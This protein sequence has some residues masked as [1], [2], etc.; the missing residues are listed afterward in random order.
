MEVR[1]AMTAQ[2]S[3]S[4][5]GPGSHSNWMRVFPRIELR[6]TAAR[7]RCILL[8]QEVGELGTTVKRSDII[9]EGLG[10]T[11]IF[12]SY[13]VRHRTDPRATLVQLVFILRVSVKKM[14]CWSCNIF[15]QW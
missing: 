14:N 11:V 8:L 3:D 10:D 12:T 1:A 4:M 5:T 2:K 9:T 7:S 13:I 15:W 6:A